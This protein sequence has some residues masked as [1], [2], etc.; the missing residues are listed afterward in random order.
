MDFPLKSG[1]L[2]LHKSK[3]T[4]SREFLR[5]IFVRSSSPTASP[6][7]AANLMPLI[8]F[9]SHK[10]QHV[11]N[12][13]VRGRKRFKEKFT[14]FNIEVTYMQ[15]ATRNSKISAFPDQLT[16]DI[17]NP[18]RSLAH[19]RCHPEVL[20]CRVADQD[21]HLPSCHSHNTN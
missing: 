17:E 1:P 15:S 21:F 12:L 5:R 4:S 13:C 8:A 20:H 2:I 18:L 16:V 10:K 19:Q 7:N 6:D 3:K 14:D 11:G 9:H